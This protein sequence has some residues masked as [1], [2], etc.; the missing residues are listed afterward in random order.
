MKMKKIVTVGLIGV[1]VVT[2]SLFLLKPK[3]QLSNEV[4]SG[5]DLNKPYIPSTLILAQERIR[6]EAIN[7][8]ESS[9][10]K[11]KITEF[12]KNWEDELEGRVI[13]YKE[14]EYLMEYGYADDGVAIFSDGTQ[15]FSTDY[16]SLEKGGHLSTPQGEANLL[17][18]TA[19]GSCGCGDMVFV[20]PY[21]GKTKTSEINFQEYEN[22]DE[23]FAQNILNHHVLTNKKGDYLISRLD[24][25]FFPFMGSNPSITVARIPLLLSLN[26]ETGKIEQYNGSNEENKAIQRMYLKLSNEM[27]DEINTYYQS[28]DKYIAEEDYENFPNI[29]GFKY[30]LDRMA[31]MSKGEAI[32]H[33]KEGYTKLTVGFNP[34]T[35]IDDILKN[36]QE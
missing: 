19:M 5:S 27:Q 16:F 36:I 34:G 23:N 10:K 35:D 9:Y 25:P 24:S 1:I 17:I 6:S 13:S 11:P 33:L 8:F 21:K 31:G 3:I 26:K 29:L 12:K 32:E 22:S 30:Q 20:Y 18:G 7:F 15:I 14:E 28:P 2:T 4:V